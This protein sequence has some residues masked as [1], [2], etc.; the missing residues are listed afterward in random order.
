[1]NF[2]SSTEQES[3]EKPVPTNA[4]FY[5]IAQSSILRDTVPVRE[6]FS[7]LDAENAVSETLSLHECDFDN[8]HVFQMDEILFVVN[9]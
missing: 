7:H 3:T 4:H 9:G 5:G 6:I 2:P 8:K 1:M